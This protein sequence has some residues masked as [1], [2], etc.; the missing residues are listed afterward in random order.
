MIRISCLCGADIAGVLDSL[1][2]LR[3]RVFREFPYLYDGSPG[4]EKRYLQTYL[5]SERSI[6]IMAWDGDQLIGASTGLP[7]A[8]EE[9]AFQ[10]PFLQQG[11]DPASV[12]YCAESV[13]LPE[14]RGQGI[15]RTFFEQREQHARQCGAAQAVFCA[16]IRADDHPLKPQGYQPLN[17]VWSHFGY[18]LL[19]GFTTEYHWQDLGETTET[20][21]LMQF[22]RKK[23]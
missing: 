23:L 2:Q 20:A 7:L 4:Y 1:A 15:Y 10:Q 5:N 9:T 8:D 14:Y 11:F 16:V 3:I 19:P 21:K 13:L 17:R 12:F 18:H 6:V 22:Y